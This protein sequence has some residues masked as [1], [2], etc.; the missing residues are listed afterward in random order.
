MDGRLADVSAYADERQAQEALV[1]AT[2]ESFQGRC[3]V[4]WA[5]SDRP[6]WRT[7]E[8]LTFTT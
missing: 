7:G 4:T 5:P 8:V 2:E 6:G 1:T 3:D